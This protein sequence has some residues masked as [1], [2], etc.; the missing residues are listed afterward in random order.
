MSQFTFFKP[1]YVLYAF[2]SLIGGMCA[3]VSC[4]NSGKDNSRQT[5]LAEKDTQNAG[6]PGGSGT[7]LT[8][9]NYLDDLYIENGP[10]GSADPLPDL[11]DLMTKKK[12]GKEKQEKVVFNFYFDNSSGGLTLQPYP[13]KEKNKNFE[14]YPLPKRL[15]S[16]SN[17]FLNVSAKNLHLASTQLL[18]K[19]F[20]NLLN[21]Y[22]GKAPY[23]YIVFRPQEKDGEISFQLYYSTAKP[24]TTVPPGFK[25]ST[26]PK[27]VYFL[28]LTRIADTDL[29]PSP[30]RNAD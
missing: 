6:M 13:T 20:D 28:T 10:V 11:T 4:D 17:H 1:N 29:N 9:I 30:P 2:C 7:A 15:V 26:N 22:L 12:P 24:T 14:D 21:N 8:T 5:L 23:P 3:V 19:D 27:A 16:T 25:K 18:K